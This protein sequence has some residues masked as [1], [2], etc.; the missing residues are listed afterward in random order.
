MVECLLVACPEGLESDGHVAGKEEDRAVQQKCRQIQQAIR[1][2]F[3]IQ[4]LFSSPLV[5]A[6]DA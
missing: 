5:A 2:D 1:L 3:D 4:F 6:G